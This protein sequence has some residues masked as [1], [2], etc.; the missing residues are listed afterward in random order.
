MLFVYALAPWM[1]THRLKISA[2]SGGLAK[3]SLLSSKLKDD[4]NMDDKVAV[5]TAEIELLKKENELYRRRLLDEERLT[6]THAEVTNEDRNTC[7]DD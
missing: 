6:I 1:R 5:L 7:A 4:P 2:P 3:S